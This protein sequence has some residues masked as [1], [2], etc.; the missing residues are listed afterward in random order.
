MRIYDT[1]FNAEVMEILEELV[2]QLRANNIPLIQKYKDGPQHIQI[3][4]PYHN[5]GQESRPSAGIRKSDGKFHCFACGEVH[6]LPE[7]ISHCFGEDSYG[8]F[9][10]K[11]LIRNF[12]TVAVE[13]RK[14]VDLDYS[15]T[16]GQRGFCSGHDDD[17]DVTGEFVTEKELDS[18]RWIHEYMYARKLTDEVIDKFDVGYDAK[19]KCITFPVRDKDGNCLFVARRSVQTKMFNIPT[20]TQKPLYGL[21][22]VYSLESMPS[23]IIVC[24][25]PIDALTAWVY[26]K[27]AVAMFGLGT[28][29]Q[30][31]QLRKLPCRKLILATDNDAAGMRAR[32][33]IRKN[34]KNKMITEYM[35]PAGKKDLND[36]TKEEFDA[37][38]EI[39]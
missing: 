14:D 20:S 26:G 11:W 12:A 22:E 33:V 34:V 24:E 18:Y 25:G 38:E 30:F 28:E 10:W 37:L 7:V 27:Y 17:R 15:R 21:F 31:D 9:G 23:E 35:L 6:E 4:C 19:T 1:E 2:A 3:C 39:F 16:G 13:E 8:K 36:L 32:E 5:N 29:L